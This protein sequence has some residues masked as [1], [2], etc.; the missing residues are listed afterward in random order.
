MGSDQ[1]ILY[2]P[3]SSESFQSTLPV[4]GATIQGTQVGA[5]IDRFQSTL[6]VW[7]AT[8]PRRDLGLRISRISIHAPRVGSDWWRDEGWLTL[9]ISIHAPRVG[10][11]LLYLSNATVFIRF[12]STLPVWG[13]TFIRKPIDRHILFQSTLPVWGATDMLS[14]GLLNRNISIHAPRVGSD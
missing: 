12:Q 8:L 3:L 11:D 7:G 10:S 14:I 5:F 4:W 9:S 1:R 2:P 13:A 6:P